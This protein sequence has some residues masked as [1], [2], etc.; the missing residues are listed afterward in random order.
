VGKLRNRRRGG[1]PAKTLTG[2]TRTGSAN[3]ILA[4]AGGIQNP[5]VGDVSAGKEVTMNL[6][7][8][9]TTEMVGRHLGCILIECDSTSGGEIL[10]PPGNPPDAYVNWSSRGNNLVAW[11]NTAGVFARFW[12]F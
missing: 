11:A 2:L 7:T 10:A 6:G 3:K 4:N 8:E 12:V 5:T 9:A 1:G